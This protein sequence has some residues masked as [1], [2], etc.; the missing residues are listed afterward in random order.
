MCQTSVVEQ[1]LRLRNQKAAGDAPALQPRC[2]LQLS[3]VLGGVEVA[4][5]FCD[6]SVVV[7]VPEFIAADPNFV[8]GSAR[9]GVRSGQRPMKRGSVSA[10]LQF[11]ERHDHVWKCC[12]ER[13]RFPG[14]RR[15]SNRGRP[16]INAN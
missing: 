14:N 4:A 1:A 12:H 8:S 11:V 5:R 6:E 2:A 9:S 16:F 7:E 13:L 15:A 10:R 3:V